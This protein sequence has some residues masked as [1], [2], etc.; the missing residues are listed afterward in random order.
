MSINI[1][2]R[3]LGRNKPEPVV[4]K[5]EPIVGIPN[6]SSE[7]LEDAKDNLDGFFSTSRRIKKG[8]TLAQ[9]DKAAFPVT[10]EDFQVLDGNGQSV[11]MDQVPSGGGIGDLKQAFTL[12][13]TRVPEQLLSWYITQNFIGYQAMSLI[14]QHWLINKICEMPAKDA[15]RHGFE[16]TINSGD[17]EIDKK[18]FEKFRKVDRDYKLR[19]HLKEAVHMNR[20]FGIR[21]V[22]FVYDGQN[23]EMPFNPDAV[24]P[25]SYRGMVQIDPYWITPELDQ[26]GVSNAAAPHFYE[27]TWWRVHGKRY[28]RSHFVILKGPKVSDI[29][30]P[31]YLYGGLSVA[32]LAYERV[33][34]AERTANEAPQLAMTKRLNTLKV[35]LGEALANEAEFM[36]NIRQWTLLRDNHGVKVIGLEEAVEQKDT[37]LANF[38][39]TVTSQYKLVGAI[40][41]IPLTKLLGDSPK[42]FQSNGENEGHDYTEELESIQDDHMTP[43][44]DRHTMMCMLSEDVKA[45]DVDKDEIIVTTWNPTRVPTSKDIADANYAKANTDS[46]LASTGAVGPEDIRKRIV[47]D[48]ESGYDGMS[49]KDMPKGGFV[50]VEAA[51]KDKPAASQEPKAGTPKTNTSTTKAKTKTAGKAQ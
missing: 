5:K 19:A 18:F 33:Y 40:G 50:P 21:H 36:E 48:P 17:K 13:G 41:N 29:L 1:I 9:W 20:V 39:E 34:A 43:I 10:P 25:G 15:V 22:L 26:E 46:L 11:A 6:A 35:D 14:S 42:G 44:V 27:P 49:V 7:V 3:I 4:Q 38:D 37:S 12:G 23:P 24:E 28:H 30:R 2:D 32:Q 51:I 16:R 31:A 8:A 45:D 47:N